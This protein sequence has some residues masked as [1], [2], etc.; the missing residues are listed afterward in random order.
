MGKKLLLT[1][2]GLVVGTVWGLF[3]LFASFN[4]LLHL[5]HPTITDPQLIRAADWVWRYLLVD[6]T[7]QLPNTAMFDMQGRRHLLDIKRL[8]TTQQTGFYIIA[9]ASFL[10]AVL[11]VPLRSTLPRLLT[12]LG[13][14]GIVLLCIIALAGLFGFLELFTAFHQVLFTGNS[15]IFPADSKLIRLFPLEYF[16][17]FLFLW[18]LLCLLGFGLLIGLGRVLSRKLAA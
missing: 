5:Y 13:L 6:S 9:A 17:Q 16:Q 4:L 14:G 7:I 10:G 12:L 3:I 11:Y 15:W 18:V 1:L 8:I 2:L